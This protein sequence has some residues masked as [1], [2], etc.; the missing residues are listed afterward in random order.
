MSYVIAIGAIIGIALIA[1]FYLRRPKATGPG[2]PVELT[3]TDTE[4]PG[5]DEARA[6]G[7]VKAPPGS[8]PDRE[9]HGKP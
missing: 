2:R 7:P 1:T 5:P 9:A 8:R 6:Q 3:S 4:I